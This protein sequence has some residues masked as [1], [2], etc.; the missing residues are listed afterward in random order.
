[1]YIFELSLEN[2]R[3]FNLHVY[4]KY[5]QIYFLVY[6]CCT[7]FLYSKFTL[8]YCQREIFINLNL[9]KD[10]Q[11]IK[12]KMSSCWNCC[13]PASAGSSLSSESVLAWVGPGAGGAGTPDEIPKIKEIAV[14]MGGEFCCTVEH[15]A[16]NPSWGSTWGFVFCLPK[17]TW[18]VLVGDMCLSMAVW[19]MLSNITL[20]RIS[21]MED[22]VELN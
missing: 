18:E 16:G 8:E 10:F 22:F 2:Y 11:K 13:G 12:I 17:M 9:I 14:S 3:R 4:K 15:C 19:E 7:I 5:W 6:W 21:L 20:G 1:M